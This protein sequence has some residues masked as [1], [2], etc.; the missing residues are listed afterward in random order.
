[1]LIQIHDYAESI[2]KTGMLDKIKSSAQASLPAKRAKKPD[3]ATVEECE[4]IKTQATGAAGFF[5]CLT[6]E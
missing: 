1:M 4:A 5:A 3:T 6:K 2:G